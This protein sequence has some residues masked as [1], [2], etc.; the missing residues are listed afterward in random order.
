M[1]LMEAVRADLI[2]D[3]GV[4]KYPYTDTVG[5][6]TIGCGRNLD[7]VGLHDDEIDL[8]L[9]NDINTAMESLDK[10]LPWWTSL[11]EVRKR[12]LVNMAF[13]L[14]INGLLKF[15]NTLKATKEGR[16]KDAADGMLASKWAT[17]VG[18]R[19]KRLSTMMRGE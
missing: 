14:G 1:T 15:T 12:V 2:R 5:K 13:N 6:L 4:R 16:Y 19:A 11:D 18:A 7:A 17:Q 8:M 9:T 10:Y 3:E